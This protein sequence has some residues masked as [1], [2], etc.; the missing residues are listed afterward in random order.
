MN[1]NDS[2]LPVLRVGRDGSFRELLGTGFL[3]GDRPMLVTARHV[4][5]Y[6]RL[7]DGDSF[8]SAIPTGDGSAVLFSFDSGPV[9]SSDS[10]VAAFAAKGLPPRFRAGVVTAATVPLPGS[11][12][13]LC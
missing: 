1:P 9:E 2:I 11:R 13:V 7:E 10:D 4:L 3:A 5:D 6:E 8:G 12:F